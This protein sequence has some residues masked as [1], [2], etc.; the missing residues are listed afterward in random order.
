MNFSKKPL[1]L[2]FFIYVASPEKR[3]GQLAQPYKIC[4][5]DACDTRLM[6][7]DRNRLWKKDG[8]SVFF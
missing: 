7:P 3:V 2:L 8:I 5:R 4:R 1:I 6:V